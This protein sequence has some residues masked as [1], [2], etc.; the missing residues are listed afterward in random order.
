MWN[1][2][3]K[4]FVGGWFSGGGGLVKAFIDEIR[5]E[6]EGETDRSEQKWKD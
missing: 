4:P 1:K 5:S 2:Q 3:N 6:I